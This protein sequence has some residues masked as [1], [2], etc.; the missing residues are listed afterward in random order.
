M[1]PGAIFGSETASLLA[2]ASCGSMSRR[3]SVAAG[4]CRQWYLTMA[5]R[6]ANGG[7]E[8][9]GSRS[10]RRHV[11]EMADVCWRWATIESRTVW[12]RRACDGEVT[13]GRVAFKSAT[14]KLSTHGRDLA[15]ASHPAAPCPSLKQRVVCSISCPRGDPDGAASG[16]EVLVH[17]HLSQRRQT[18]PPFVRGHVAFPAIIA[19]RLSPLALLPDDPR[20]FTSFPPFAATQRTAC[21]VCDTRSLSASRRLHFIIRK[22]LFACPN[23]PVARSRPNSDTRVLLEASPGVGNITRDANLA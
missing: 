20:M 10:A 3:G 22:K 4:G 16:K 7:T 23:V 19:P 6:S 9:S 13:G 18:S 11:W 21:F 12:S 8:S 1:V 17:A 15:P 5:S 14:G 2:G